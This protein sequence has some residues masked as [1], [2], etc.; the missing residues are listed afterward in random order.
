MKPTHLAPDGAF[1]ERPVTVSTPDES[2]YQAS[3]LTMDQL[4]FWTGQQL[5][6]DEALFQMGGLCTI[7]GP[8]DTSHFQAAFQGVIDRCDA[9]RTVIEVHD[10]IP[11]RKV[12]ETCQYEMHCVDFSEEV[13]PREA[14]MKWASSRIRKPLDLAVCMFDSALAKLSKREYAWHYCMH[15]LICDAWSLSLILERV[16]AAYR[17]SLDGRLAELG[18]YPAFAEYIDFERAYHDSERYAEAEA[19]WSRRMSGAASLSFLG[20]IARPNTT[21]V[22]RISCQLSSSIVEALSGQINRQS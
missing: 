17:L 11:R 18:T 7:G 10:G 22:E 19:Y 21:E 20:S 3:N 13:N 16:A 9:L 5:Q 1:S 15:H 4:L 12:R 2:V 6:Q 14:A 8:V